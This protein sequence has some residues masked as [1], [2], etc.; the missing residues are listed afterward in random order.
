M[1]WYEDSRGERLR[2]REQGQGPA[3]VL[4]H[5]WCMS[6]AV[7][8]LQ[9]D[10]LSARFRVIAPDLRGHGDSPVGSGECRLETFCSDI[11]DLFRYLD[12][13][14][15][16]L[17]GWSQG[18][19]VA[20]RA[21]PLLQERLSGLV[22]ICGTPLFTS[23]ADFPHGL[24]PAEAQGMALKVRRN[25]K[26]ALEG[27]VARM[28]VPGELAAS[29]REEEIRALLD[30]VP[31]PETA[32]A[33]QSLASLAEADLRKQLAAIDRP[34]LVISGEHDPICP[35]AA[36]A[37]MA[38]RIPAGRHVTYAGCGHAPFLTRCDGFNAGL[39]DFS[40]EVRGAYV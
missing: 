6:S 36:S 8:S 27:F 12:L 33:L 4:I 28:F 22:L 21:V 39:A 26:R 25:L 13:N 10:R 37:F 15:A 7:W 32:V 1:P 14:G 20:V 19:Q 17:A 40:R 18:A 31:V 9:L 35:S 3:L 30:A 34:T 29:G 16:I 2:Y 38:K 11:I 5:G 23:A 24:A